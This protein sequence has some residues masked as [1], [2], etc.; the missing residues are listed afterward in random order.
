MASSGVGTYSGALRKFLNSIIMNIEWEKRK[1]YESNRKILKTTLNLKEQESFLL[2]FG[3]FPNSVQL[4][5]ILLNGKMTIVKKQIITDLP[6]LI[7]N[8]SKIGNNINQFVHLANANKKTQ[9]AQHLKE[10]LEEVKII[11]NTF[12]NENKTN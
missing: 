2:K 5:E 3:E 9:D 7:N 6:I 8:I 12:I 11:L 10:L 1:K 4:K